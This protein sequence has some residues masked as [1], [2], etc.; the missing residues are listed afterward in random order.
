MHLLQSHKRLSPLTAVSCRSCC[1]SMPCPALRRCHACVRLSGVLMPLHKALLQARVLFMGGTNHGSDFT[2]VQY[3]SQLLCLW[4]GL[5]R[6][7]P[8]SC[9]DLQDDH[10]LS[11]LLRPGA[12][13]ASCEGAASCT[14]SLLDHPAWCRGVQPAALR[15]SCRFVGS[16]TALQPVRVYIPCLCCRSKACRTE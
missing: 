1:A 6:K 14:A 9:L 16:G 5:F 11:L 3:L 7:T 15:S 10:P 4:S 2:L 12:Q 13:L 8:D